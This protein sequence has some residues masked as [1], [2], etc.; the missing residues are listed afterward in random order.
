MG[1]PSGGHDVT[2]SAFARREAMR[3][4]PR[5]DRLRD[6]LGVPRRVVR[7]SSSPRS[8]VW[9]A[10]L[11]EAVA[12]VK[13]VVGGPDAAQRYQREVT[14]LTVAGRVRPAV[15]PAVLA[16][17]EGARLIALEY[18]PHRRPGLDWVLDWACALARLHAAAARPDEAGLL[19]LWS[20][21]TQ[22]DVAAFLRFA[23][24]LEVVIP[25]AAEEE[26]AALLVRLA[27]TGQQALL[28]G[29][30]CPDNALHTESGVRFVDFERACLGRGATELAYL[31]AGFP[32]C[33]CVTSISPELLTEA[34][35]AYRESWRRHG[36]GQSSA[37]AEVADACAGWL[38]R[39]DAL[40][41][42]AERGRR[43]HFDR[44]P[45]TDW[46][47]GTVTA[48]ERVAHRLGSLASFDAARD[49]LPALAELAG[50][51][52]IR[53]IGRWPGLSPPPAMRSG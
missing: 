48:R 39:G 3:R 18:L 17:D 29:D 10:E 34:E 8:R 36:T 25:P 37:A 42:A 20:A 53:M 2:P 47:W 4:M 35:T 43:E 31:R 16:L 51:L 24:S 46:R 23:R 11:A 28:H 40:V 27:G 44:L 21:P 49:S 33:W 19:P 41:Q 45:R 15:T 5:S 38:V 52:Q 32:T 22:Q 6:E 30:P 13:Q 7:L 26:L 14:A 12:V 50:A 9:R 1:T